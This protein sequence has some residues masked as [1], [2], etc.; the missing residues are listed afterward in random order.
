MY[1][2][3]LHFLGKEGDDPRLRMS[4]NNMLARGVEVR[5]AYVKRALDPSGR[6]GSRPE[7]R[8]DSRY[9]WRPSQCQDEGTVNLS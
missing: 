2:I 8:Q 9:S 1:A 3:R 4:L 6:R 7:C 5:K